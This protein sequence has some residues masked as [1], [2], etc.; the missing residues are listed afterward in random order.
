MFESDRFANDKTNAFAWQREAITYII[1]FIVVFSLVYYF[2][3]FFSELYGKIPDWA[4][5]LAGRLR[6]VDLEATVANRYQ[7]Q[8]YHSLTIH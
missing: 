4:T 8:I 1:M 7:K 6:R 3:V 2:V 5:R